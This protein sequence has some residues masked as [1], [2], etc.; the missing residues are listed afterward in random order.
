MLAGV[1][2]RLLQDFD[3]R[4]TVSR[5]TAAV[6]VLYVCVTVAIVLVVGGTAGLRNPFVMPGQNWKVPALH[7]LAGVAIVGTR[8]L[9]SVL[10]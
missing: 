2:L 4:A 3:G 6:F 8:R 10:G 1:G 7:V 5:R 9:K